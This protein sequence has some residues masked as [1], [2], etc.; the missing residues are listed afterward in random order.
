MSGAI[1]I[2][3]SAV[4]GTGGVLIA[5]IGIYALGS[6]LLMG[7]HVGARGRGAWL[8]SFFRELWIAVWTQ[9]LIPLFYVVGRR[10]DPFFLRRGREGIAKAHADAGAPVPIV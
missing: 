6:F 2:A 10:M 4:V 3:E 7:K 9:P 5:G 1:E 8:R